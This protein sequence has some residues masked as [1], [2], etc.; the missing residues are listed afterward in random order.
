MTLAE[1]YYNTTNH[2]STQLSPFEVVYDILPPN[3]LSY[4]PRTTLVDSVDD[5]LKAWEEVLLTLKH[6]LKKSQNS[7]KEFTD[8]KRKHM[9]FEVGDF[10]YLKL[11]SYHQLLVFQQRNLR[12]APRYYGPYKILEKIG[13][14]AYRL[15]LPPMSKI[16][17]VF[18]VS[19]FKKHLGIAILTTTKLS[20]IF[21]SR[22]MLPILV[23]MPDR[24]LIN[25]GNHAIVELLIRWEGQTSMD[26]TWIP[27]PKLLS[28]YPDLLG[29]VF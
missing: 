18:H 14:I 15:Q 22:E 29:K 19:Q 6:Q 5:Y 17:Q 26:V 10:V 16:H 12:L 13:I 23:E 3:L 28:K 27:Y 24:R 7:L 21:T 9:E 11:Q 1:F 20:I 8:R 4:V 2:S 25:K